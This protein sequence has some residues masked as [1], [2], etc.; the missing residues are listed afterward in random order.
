MR[1]GHLLNTWYGIWSNGAGVEDDLALLMTVW[2]SGMEIGTS[3][4]STDGA[5]VVGI[6]GGVWYLWG[7]DW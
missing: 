5:L 3:L 2:I 7:E 6:H 4:N 1:D